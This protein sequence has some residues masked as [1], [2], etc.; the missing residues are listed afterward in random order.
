M[1]LKFIKFGVVG[2]SGM[3]VDFGVTYLLK[4]KAKLNKFLSNSAGFVLAATNNYI[5][6][7]LW[8]FHS[9]NEDIPVEYLSFFIISLIGLGIN[10]LTIYLLAD[11]LKW[12]FYFSKLCATAIVMVWNFTMNLF[13]TFR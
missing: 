8:T 13:F 2:C 10:N 7:R 12:N 5:W 9:K 3:I 4:E 6:N 11:R 1:L